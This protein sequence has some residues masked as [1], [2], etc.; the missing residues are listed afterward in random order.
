[1]FLIDIRRESEFLFRWRYSDPDALGVL[2]RS[3]QPPRDPGI[4]RPSAAHRG[5]SAL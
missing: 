2:G 5:A 4:W 1:M 3:G